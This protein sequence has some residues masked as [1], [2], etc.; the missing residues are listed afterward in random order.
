M[1]D[2]AQAVLSAVVR[3]LYGTPPGDPRLYDND[4]TGWGHVFG[5]SKG[6]H[7][8]YGFSDSSYGFSALIGYGFSLSYGTHDGSGEGQIVG[9]HDGGGID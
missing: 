7:S 4:G 6:R 2:I 3:T 8:V 9:H 1:S 5:S